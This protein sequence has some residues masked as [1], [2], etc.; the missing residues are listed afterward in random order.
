MVQPD[1]RRRQGRAAAGF[2]GNR[3]NSKKL[4]YKLSFRLGLRQLLHGARLHGC[5][6]VSTHTA[7]RCL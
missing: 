7:T 2:N 1:S 6:Q 5:L 3:V 4:I